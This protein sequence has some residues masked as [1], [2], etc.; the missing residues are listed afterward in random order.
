MKKYKKNYL[1]AFNYSEGDQILS[2]ITG[3]LAHDIHHIHA[4]KSGGSK[5]LDEADNLIALSRA[6]HIVIEDRNVYYRDWLKMIHRL[7]TG[8]KMCYEDIY[9]TQKLVD[10]SHIDPIYE[11]FKLAVKKV[12]S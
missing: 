10:P 8:Y 3:T 2:E 7:Y 5:E 12:L 6:E 4:R 11:E 1:D 9:R